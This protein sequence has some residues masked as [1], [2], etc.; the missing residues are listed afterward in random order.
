MNRILLLSFTLSVFLSVNSYAQ[1]EN[2]F[3]YSDENN[4]DSSLTLLGPSQTK[5]YYM[6]EGA[7]F[8]FKSKHDAKKF[9]DSTGS[10][11]PVKF[12]EIDFN[13]NTLVLLSYHGGDCHARFRYYTVKNEYSKIFTVCIDVI[14]GG[15]RA[16]G[17]FFT[18]WALIP[19]Q[20]EDYEVKFSTRMVDREL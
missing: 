9:I 11:H 14:Y 4:P 2:L 6:K 16:G 19:K 13:I 5:F 15:C 17:Y 7:M 20:P 3:E 12:D 8:I 10:G 1:I 18:T